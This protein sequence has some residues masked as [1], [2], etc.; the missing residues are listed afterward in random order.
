M[1]R[2]G[3]GRTRIMAR[4]RRRV[5]HG[6][7]CPRRTV[8]LSAAAALLRHGW[9]MWGHMQMCRWGHTHVRPDADPLPAGAGRGMV[10]MRARH[11]TCPPR[12]DRDSQ[13]GAHTCAAR[14]GPSAGRGR[15]GGSRRASSAGPLMT[16]EKASPL[17]PFRRHFPIGAVFPSSLS[18]LRVLV[19]SQD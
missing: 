15:E 19:S 4:Y 12:S 8:V 16:C 13:M 3:E 7:L 14:C 17:L 11:G 6:A 9:G 5:A 2:G 10:A 1:G 18:H